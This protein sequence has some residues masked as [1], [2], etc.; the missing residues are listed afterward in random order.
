MFIV[1]TNYSLPW[2][3]AGKAFCLDEVILT[4][5]EKASIYHVSVCRPFAMCPSIKLHI[6][7]TE[8][9]KAFTHVRMLSKR[10]FKGYGNGYTIPL[11]NLRFFRMGANIY[12]VN[13]L[14]D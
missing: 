8:G 4:E 3:V 7:D 1:A 2:S 9:N 6:K 12:A 10:N 13:I 5:K 14:G 11:R